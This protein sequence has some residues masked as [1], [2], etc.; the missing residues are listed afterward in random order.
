MKSTNKHWKIKMRFMLSKIN[1]ETNSATLKSSSLI[2]SFLHSELTKNH[3]M[4]K[5][6]SMISITLNKKLSMKW[7]KKIHI[8]LGESR[9]LANKALLPMKKWRLKAKFSNTK[10]LKLN[11]H[12]LISKRSSSERKLETYKKK[13][14]TLWTSMINIWLAFSCLKMTTKLNSTI[15]RRLERSLISNSSRPNGSWTWCSNSTYLDSW[16]HSLFP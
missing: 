4:L 1:K 11:T 8:W 3:S 16:F 15:L 10:T 12:W 6:L 7:S 2:Q 5:N 14:S 9:I 13:G